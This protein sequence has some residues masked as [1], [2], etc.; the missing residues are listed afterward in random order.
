MAI[1]L[2][3]YVGK[4]TSE[5]IDRYIADKNEIYK[6]LLEKMSANDL[7]SEIKNTLNEL[8]QMGLKMAVGSSSKN[9][10]LILEKI[11][12]RD[13]FDAVSDG[14]NIKNSKPDPE[15]FLMAANMLALIP[16]DC[17]VV[18][19]AIAGLQSAKAGGMDCAAVGDAALSELADYKLQSFKEI[20]E[21]VLN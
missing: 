12:L 6:E 10:K 20:K 7:S 18:E 21:I 5:E 2:E 15:V 13:F 16:G 1:I 14:T 4:L 8:R 11:G 9:A 3:D 19:D 17:L